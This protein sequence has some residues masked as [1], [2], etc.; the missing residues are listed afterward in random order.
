MTDTSEPAQTVVREEQD[1]YRVVDVVENQATG[2][3]ITAKLKRG[4]GTRDQDEIRIKAKGRD[5]EEAADEL[6]AVL[7]RVDEWAAEFRA[8]QPDGEE[9]A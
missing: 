1:Q 7:E 5:A 3:S 2:V 9:G 8:V 4:T 6:D